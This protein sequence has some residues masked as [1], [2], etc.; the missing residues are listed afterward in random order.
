MQSLTDTERS[1]LY[2]FRLLMGFEIDLILDC[3]RYV[4]T[5]KLV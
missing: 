4:I 2:W 1:S 3:L 5:H